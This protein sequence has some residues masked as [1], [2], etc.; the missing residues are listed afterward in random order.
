P[1]ELRLAHGRVG[2]LGRLELKPRGQFHAEAERADLKEV[3]VLKDGVLDGVPVEARARAAGTVPDV[4]AVR[5]PRDDAGQVGDVAGLQAQVAAARPS[6]NDRVSLQ[7]AM[8]VRGVP[9]GDNERSLCRRY[10]ILVSVDHAVYRQRMNE[11][12]PA[13]RAGPPRESTG[14]SARLGG[15]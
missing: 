6:E 2:S 14:P 1:L 3:A 8:P 15:A 7:R 11:V 12:P 4:E 13:L 9:V 10:G 5:P